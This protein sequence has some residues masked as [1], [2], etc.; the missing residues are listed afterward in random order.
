MSDAQHPQSDDLV[1]QAVAALRQLPIPGGPS[2]TVVLKT[3]AALR[4]PAAQPQSTLMQRIPIMPWTTKAIAMLAAAASVLVY[5]ALS[6]SANNDRAFADVAKALE[7]IRT[8]TY[9]GSTEMKGPMNGQATTI[10]MKGFF[11]APSRERLEMSTSFGS[12]KDKTSSVIILDHQAMKGLTLVPEQKLAMTVDLAKIKKPVGPSNSFDMA[13]QLVQEGS[14]S[15]GKVESLGNKEIGGRMAIGFRVRNN[16]ADQTFWVDLQTARLVRV[17]FDYPDGSGY[18]VMNNFRYDMELDPSLFSLEPPAGYTVQ[19]LEV[20]MPTED[21]LINTLRLIGEHNDG[22][23]PST[24]GLMSKE[25]QQ[26]IQAVTMEETERLLKTPDVQKAMEKLKAQYGKDKD[27]FMKAWMKQ[28]MEM[29]SPPNQKRL[30]EQMQGMNFYNTLTANNDSHYAGKDVKLG[31]PDRPIFWYKPAGT[32]KYRVI[33][34]DL[35]TQVMS[36]DEIEK[37][38]EAKSK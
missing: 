35:S 29:V 9:D 10:T 1:S 11:L 27:G 31:T 19:N 17:E 7:H 37:L 4:Q 23:F 8:A 24:L 26:A 33:Y 20:K 14:S 30:L 36:S 21:D 38:S 2:E 34:A 15:Q 6:N 13:R 16:L 22:I 3:S 28:W 5:L 25:F 12:A 32:E 18:G